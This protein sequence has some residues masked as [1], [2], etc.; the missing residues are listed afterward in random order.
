M[1]RKRDMDRLGHFLLKFAVV[2]INEDLNSADP[3]ANGLVT[4]KLIASIM[5]KAENAKMFEFTK[6]DAETMTVEEVCNAMDVEIPE[7]DEC[8]EKVAEV[9]EEIKNAAESIA[10]KFGLKKSPKVTE[11]KLSDEQ[12]K[13]F[14]D[15]LSSLTKGKK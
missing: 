4:L 10:K 13:I 11:I 6:K 5:Q 12:A 7:C 15:M 8:K 9:K 3:R 14:G 2:E 1:S